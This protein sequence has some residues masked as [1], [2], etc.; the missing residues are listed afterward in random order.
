MAR[1]QCPVCAAVSIRPIDY[2]ARTPVLM[3]R[4]YPT[5]AAARAS[6]QGTLDI[7]ACNHCGF[8]W[9][10]AFEPALV[11]YDADYENDQTHSAAFAAHIADRAADVVR[12]VPADEPIDYLEIG[13]GQ[14]AFIGDVSHAAGKRV[15]SA[16]GFD[17]A[18]RG[19]DRTGPD[20]SRIHKVYFTTETAHR[21]SHSP[22][23]VASRHTIEHVPDPIAFLSAIRAALGPG[24]RARL[25]IETPCIDWILAHGAM[26]D[27]FYEHCSIFTAAAL[28]H[29]MER[30]GFGRVEVS[31]VFGGQYL[32]ASGIAGARIEETA[33]PPRGQEPSLATGTA[34]AGKWRQDVQAARQA[35]AVALWGAGAKGVTFALLTDSGAEI[36][37]CAIDINPGKQGLH[38]AGTGL[39]VLSPQAAAAQNP[40]TIFVMNPNYLDEIGETMRACGIEARLVPIN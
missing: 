7:V 35:G 22:N 6:V 37:A 13:C 36:F 40:K 25:F 30:S 24:S 4:L 33:L 27:L 20:G 16:E 17:P 29:A 18:W 3:N 31:H 2:R 23:V 34:F 21:L 26:Q 38:L 14:G 1:S 32:W 8:A 11:V 39:Q 12:A 10:R 28:R 9:N 15:R 5:Q 19:L